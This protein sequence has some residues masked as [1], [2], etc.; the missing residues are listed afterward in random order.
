MTTLKDIYKLAEALG[1]CMKDSDLFD[2]YQSAKKAFDEDKEVGDLVGQFNLVRMN[3]AEESDKNEPDRSR[4]DAY[5]KES[6]RLYD[7][8]MKNPT[9]AALDRANLALENMIKNVNQILQASISDPPSG[10][11]HDCSTCGGCHTK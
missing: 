3:I 6:Q 10:C 1:D 11:T 4:I 7:E 5:T 2:E 9:M 8:I